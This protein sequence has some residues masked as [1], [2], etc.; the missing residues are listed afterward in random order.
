MNKITLIKVGL[1]F[2]DA[3]RRILSTPTCKIIIVQESY[4]IKIVRLTL[5][6]RC[7]AYSWSSSNKVS[8]WSPKRDDIYIYKIF[9]FGRIFLTCKCNGN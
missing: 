8:I 2:N 3:Q 6:A 7:P 1:S 9:Y 5:L 4:Q